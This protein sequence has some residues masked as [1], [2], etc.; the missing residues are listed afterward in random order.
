MRERYRIQVRARRGPWEPRAGGLASSG[1]RLGLLTSLSHSLG[2][3]REGL[4]SPH[5]LFALRALSDGAGPDPGS[6]RSCKGGWER[7]GW[8]FS[9]STGK[10]RLIYINWK[11]C[12]VQEEGLAAGWLTRVTD[13]HNILS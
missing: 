3:H 7:E 11:I 1:A 10:E 5:L 13:V 12:Q 2:F 9:A 4:G 6:W 8:T